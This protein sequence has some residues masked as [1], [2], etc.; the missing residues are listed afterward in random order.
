MNDGISRRRFAGLAGA[1]LA[2]GLAP[3]WTP[4]NADEFSRRDD[5]HNRHLVATIQEL[6]RYVLPHRVWLGP[7]AASHGVSVEMVID[8]VINSVP[9]P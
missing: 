2:A 1:T 7:H 5:A 6:A 9:V 3:S 8:D 4:A